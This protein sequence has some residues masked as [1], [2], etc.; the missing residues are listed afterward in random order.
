MRRQAMTTIRLPRSMYDD[1]QA[2]TIALLK[3]LKES[4][5][6]IWVDSEDPALAE[7]YNYCEYYADADKMEGWDESVGHLG[8][9][10]RRVLDLLGKAGWTSRRAAEVIPTLVA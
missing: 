3:V 6:F 2:D 7:L 8:A 9:K 4:P 10:A 5:R 1:D